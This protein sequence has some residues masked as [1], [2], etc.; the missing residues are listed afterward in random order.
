[1]QYRPK[2]SSHESTSVLGGAR[3]LVSIAFAIVIAL[4]LFPLSAYAQEMSSSASPDA[5]VNGRA[6]DANMSS[7]A[8]K[9]AQGSMGGQDSSVAAHDEG[10]NK[11]ISQDESSAPQ[12]GIAPADDEGSNTSEEQPSTEV[13]DVVAGIT[14]AANTTSSSASD[15][16]APGEGDSV[17][18][19]SIPAGHSA[20]WQLIDGKWYYFNSAGKART[21]WVKSGSKWYY[22]DPEDA[23]MKTGLYQVGGKWYVSNASGAMAANAW[24]QADGDWYYATGSGALKTGWHK[25][26]GKWYWLQPEKNGLMASECWVKDGLDWYYLT[27]SGA[28]KVGWQLHKGIWYYL[29]ESGA[30]A[31]G[32][33]KLKGIWYY[34]D[35][36]SEGAMKTGCYQV[37]DT[38]YVSRASGAMAANEWAQADG[39]WYYATGSGALKTGWHKSSGKW[40][41]LQPEKNG[42]M[43]S[44]EWVNDGSADY[45]M[46]KSGAMFT[47]WLSQGSADGLANGMFF[48][49][50]KVIDIALAEIGYR[51]KATDAQLDSKT[52]NAGSGNHTKYGRDMHAI[53]PGIME[54][55]DAWC[56]AFVDWCF[57]QAFGIENARGLLGGSFNDYTPVS[58][59][60]F[61]DQMSW[62][63]NAPQVG[64]Q[65]FFQSSGTIN[66]TGIVYAVG[67]GK[68][69][70]V[71]GNTS[72]MVAKREY[73]LNAARIAGYGRP[74]Y[75]N[76]GDDGKFVQAKEW[77]YLGASGARA[78]G[79]VKSEGNWYYF[80]P[81][82]GLMQ[83][84]K[85]AIDGKT[86]S[87]NSAGVMKTGWSKEGSK[88][89]YYG[90]SGALQTNTWVEDYY[91]G[92]DGVM[93]TN[94]WIGDRYVDASGKY[95][96]GMQK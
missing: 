73:A 21:G 15:T 48:D 11:I 90:N 14:T 26:G 55:A 82:T 38:W 61:K 95:V 83:R 20:G 8:V 18:T 86:Y 85:K 81:A 30:M 17:E 49:K 75:N 16:R 40:Y 91:V 19:M 67:N 62:H 94:T 23:V 70:T 41:W 2:L 68:L 43:A 60:L 1:M 6:A 24:A 64:D 36:A 79:W 13:E 7:S 46:T 34:L 33:K 12:S 35:P 71:E 31:T 37:G 5:Q 52:A 9:T 78:T 47:G 57:V 93:A 29:N 56:D 87:F 39:D 65:V 22:L 63:S 59:Q 96:P 92:A 69:Y 89:Y 45:F 58:A 51:E 28:M 25:S 54:Y 74:L 80:D 42:L 66:H 10:S 88:W 44:G 32:W 27:S 84:G 53:D 50:Q 3:A 72:D 4:L 77:C 76:R